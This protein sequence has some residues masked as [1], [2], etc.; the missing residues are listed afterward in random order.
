NETT[1]KFE[2]VTRENLPDNLINAFNGDSKAYNALILAKEEDRKEVIRAIITGKTPERFIRKREGR[3]GKIFEYVPK[4]YF[5]KALNMMF[6][7]N[8]WNSTVKEILTR[9]KKD[10]KGRTITDIA[11]VVRL[12]YIINGQMNY[13]EQAGAGEA[14]PENSFGD[15]LKSAITDGLKKCCSQLGIAGDV[16]GQSEE[17]LT[18]EENEDKVTY[19]KQQL[20]AALDRQESRIVSGEAKE[21]EILRAY[22]WLK[23]TKYNDLILRARNLL[24]QFRENE[25]TAG[26]TEES[27]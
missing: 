9:E 4:G 7:L 3:G 6:G 26:K 10:G 1:D 21:V 2:V 16:Y 22:N 8:G 18:G 12:E 14:Y 19:N 25:R 20:E 13:K 27:A 15:A 24:E 23:T 17:D 11:V 5:E